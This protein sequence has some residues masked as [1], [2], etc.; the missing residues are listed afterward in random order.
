ML[1]HVVLSLLL[2]AGFTAPS[3]ASNAAS[4]PMVAGAL[5]PDQGDGASASGNPGFSA[6][7]V[8]D[9]ARSQ[10]VA[11]QDGIAPGQ[12]VW[13]VFAQELN[14]GWH[15]YWRNPGASGLPLELS[16]R[17]PEGFQA[18]DIVYPTP[19]RIY[20]G[21]LANF[22]H[23]GEPAFLVEIT[24]PTDAVPG[25]TVE[26][27]AD[28][29]WL[30][31]ADICVPEEGAFTLSLPVKTAASVNPAAREIF[32]DARAN[33]PKTVALKASFDIRD[34]RINLLFEDIPALVEPVFFPDGDA[35]FNPSADQQPRLEDDTLKV[36]LRPGWNFDADQVSAIT[37]VIADAI[38]GVSYE[39]DARPSARPLVFDDPAPNAAAINAAAPSSPLNA[40]G[41]AFLFFAAFLGG[42]LLN[43]MPCVFPII[44]IKASSLV[45]S[46]HDGGAA[47]RRHGVIYTLGVIATFTAL[48]GALLVLR[49]GGENLGWGFHLQSPVVVAI[50]SFVLFAVGLNLAG[51]FDIGESLQGAGSGLAGQP[52]DLGAFFTGALA[53]AVAAPC[54][55]PF[56]SAPMAAAVLLPPLAGLSIFILMAL[57]LAAPYLAISFSPALGQ[58]LPKPG[59]WMGV[60]KQALSFPVFAAAAY[61]LWVLAQQTGGAGLAAALFGA[62]LIALAAWA[63]ERSKG[64]A[65]FRLPVRA[66]ALIALIAAIAPATQ[67]QPIARASVSSNHGA[68]AAMPYDASA[69]ADL[70]AEGRGVFVDFTAA[71]C[72]TCQ[73]NKATVF[74]RASVAQAFDRS[75]VAVMVADWTSRDPEITDALA[76]FGANGVPLYVFYPPAGDPKTLPLPL[77]ASTVISTISSV[78]TAS[79]Q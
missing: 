4:T 5:D 64:L 75:D 73:F 71:W 78:E 43:L 53:V 72:V 54:I 74:S 69:I 63:F 60:F 48:G 13:L 14:Q 46:A 65:K 11:E 1:K 22:G 6:A 27:S 7:V 20:V 68:L 36:T 25:E 19:E 23:H 9:N 76:S 67:L 32:A 31:C 47:A 66:V 15:V 77:S 42:A 34:D 18:G 17:L 37:G 38:T 70:R 59:P 35:I 30:I 49:A 12:S 55:G 3:F 8:T 33:T 16:W 62:I 44:F 57:G 24:A 40:G 10:L 26:V 28:A 50:S 79:V 21:D 58:L 39:V 41:V 56:L 52:G 61:F 45:K 51:V 2:L 29:I